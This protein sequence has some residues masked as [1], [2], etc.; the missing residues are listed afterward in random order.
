ME[1]TNRLPLPCQLTPETG[2]VLGDTLWANYQTSAEVVLPDD[3]TQYA[4][5]GI[6]IRQDTPGFVLHLHADGG[7]LLCYGDRILKSGNVPDFSAGG[8]HRIGIGAMESLVFC[9]ADGHS[10]GEIKL[11][12]RPIVRSGGVMLLAS[13]EQITFCNVTAQPLPAPVPPGCYRVGREH[14]QTSE[15]GTVSEIRFYGSGIFLLGKAEQAN[16]AFWL[17]GT[18]YSEAIHIEKSEPD[19]AFFAL[20]PLKKGWHTLRMQVLEGSLAA[21]AFEIPTEDTRA[22]YDISTFPPDPL[23]KTEQRKPS[24]LKKAAPFA[25]AAAGTVLALT[26]GA[27]FRKKK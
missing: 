2:K 5:I 10:L 7:W 4:A 13:D 25:A 17:D 8:S 16:A 14:I 11:H 19:E 22:V 12:D 23:K 21:E 20:A 18:L 9:F 6:R 26:I 27:A 24:P 3:P 15:D 1:T